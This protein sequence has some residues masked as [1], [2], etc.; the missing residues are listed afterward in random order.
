[1]DFI[2]AA[3]GVV[4]GIVASL[5][6]TRGLGSLL[7]EVPARDPLVLVSTSALLLA[8]STIAGYLPARRAMIE[9]PAAVLRSE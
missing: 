6:V 1:M 7:Y 9:N 4:I 8:V 5:T 2:A 3:A